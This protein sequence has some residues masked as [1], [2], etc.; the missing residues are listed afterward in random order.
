MT[1]LSTRTLGRTGL[2]VAVLGFGAME[3]RDEPKGRALDEG[4]VERLLNAVLDLGITLIDTSIDYGRSEERIGRH[5]AHRRSEFVL[6][7]KCGCPVDADA[8]TASGGTPHDYTGANI[9]AGVE[10]SLRRLRTDHLDLLQVHMSPSV[11]EMERAG[12]LETLTDL[13]DEGKVR[14]LGMSGTRPN[15]VDHLA[16]DLFDVF[17]I[18]YSLL[19]P[20][21]APL[22]SR[23]AG[24]G[25]GVL[26]R[27]A[28][29]RG[30]FAVGGPS[31]RGTDLRSTWDAA[32]LDELGEGMTPA[33]FTLRYTISHPG[34]TSA[35]AGTA[36]LD[37]LR[38]NV[39]AVARGPLP[40]ELLAE[41]TR[42]VEALPG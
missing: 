29:G 22:I 34:V 26:A 42:R 32:G 38:A 39:E 15:L 21:D 31:R 6:A 7:S 20:E 24:S 16:L 35:L 13:R 36:S 19:E 10:Q 17:Q 14:F 33:E 2:E 41:A 27:G 28:T 9:R 3:L 4:E 12:T 18:P 5:L 40:D 25:V 37:H 11:A 1:D 30:A 8:R 23:A